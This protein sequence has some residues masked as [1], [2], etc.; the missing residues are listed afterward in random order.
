MVCFVLLHSLENFSIPFACRCNRL[1]NPHSAFRLFPCLYAPCFCA[2]GYYWF[3]GVGIS[4]SYGATMCGSSLSGL[5]SL[6]DHTLTAYG[7][8][9]GAAFL[10]RRIVNETF[11]L[12]TSQPTSQPTYQPSGQPSAVPTGEPSSQPSA[13]PSNQ[14]SSQPT[15]SPTFTFPPTPSPTAAARRSRRLQS[16]DYERLTTPQG[17]VSNANVGFEHISPLSSWR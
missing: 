3:L 6:G 15:S 7:N 13:A 11:I 5:L 9:T 8:N 1:T 17:T 10:Y 14:P 4:G 12:P 2:C 16:T